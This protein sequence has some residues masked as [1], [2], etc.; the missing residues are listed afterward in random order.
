MIAEVPR[1]RRMKDV[2]RRGH[3]LF[4]VPAGT[5]VP[6][7]DTEGVHALNSVRQQ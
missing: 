4:L 3:F 6:F 1:R 7:V 2:H 5:A